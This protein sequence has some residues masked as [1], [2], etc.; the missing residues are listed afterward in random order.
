MS[1]IAGFA[2]ASL[3]LTGCAGTLDTITSR[4]FRQ[5]PFNTTYR[6]IRPEDPMAVLRADPPR[7]GDERAKAMLRLKEPLRN[8]GTQQDQDEVIDLLARTAT[9]DPSAVLRAAAVSALGRFEDPR[10]PGVLIVAY[11]KAHGR[12]EGVAATAD[13]VVPVG[14]RSAGRALSSI[15]LSGPVGFP[16][17]QVVALRSACLESL[18]KT[19]RPEV[20]RF[21]AAVANGPSGDTAVEGSD[22]REVRLAAVRGLGDCRQPDAVHALA[23]V[24]AAESGKDTAMAGGAHRGLVRLTGKRLPPDPQQWNEVIQTGVTIAPEPGWLGSKVEY[25]IEW[26]R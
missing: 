20:I 10:A 16:P 9:A 11:Q 18:G 3:A 4:S 25:A 2:V 5:D 21:L 26:V 12:P 19:G 1:S 14:G 13:T 24:M 8:G 22:D 7:S 6:A 23:H 15:P 17:D